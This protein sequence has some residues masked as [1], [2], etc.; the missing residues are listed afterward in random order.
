MHRMVTKGHVEEVTFEHNFEWSEDWSWFSLDSK[1]IQVVTKITV[2]RAGIKNRQRA[3]EFGKYHW[4][5][6]ISHK[7]PKDHPLKVN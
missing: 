1:K 5:V 6:Q 7:G 3:D 4:D 2:F